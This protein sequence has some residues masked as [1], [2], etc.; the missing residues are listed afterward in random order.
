MKKILV[1]VVLGAASMLVAQNPANAAQPAQGQ[2]AQ[3]QAGQQQSPAQAPVAPVIKDPAEYNAYMGA[4][5]QKEPAGQISGLEAYL[6]QYP[7]SV[8]KIAAL[9]TLMQDYQ[10]TNNQAKRL[11]P[12][13][14]WWLPTPAMCARWRCCPTSIGSKRKAVIRMPNR[15]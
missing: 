2:P 1:T 10:Q 8:M 3:G 14:S 9:Q 12:R 15:I 11:K 5:Q 13:K 4:I 6:T 7:N